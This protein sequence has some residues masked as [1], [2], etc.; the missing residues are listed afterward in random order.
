MVRVSTYEESQP[1]LR[2][3]LK[4]LTVYLGLVGFTALLVGGIGVANSVQVFLKGK[5]DTLAILKCL[6]AGSGVIFRVYLLQTTCL[7]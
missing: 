4:N 2:R 3:F 5:L 1:R 6:G 7:G